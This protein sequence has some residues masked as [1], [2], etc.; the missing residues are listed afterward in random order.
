[1][2]ED[3]PDIS[4]IK[5]ALKSAL[6]GDVAVKPF[7]DC[8]PPICDEISNSKQPRAELQVTRAL[9]N[10]VMYID[11]VL[12]DEECKA[13]CSSVDNSS[14]LSFWSEAG[15]SNEKA[16]SFRDA[17]TIEV[18]SQEIADRIWDRIKHIIDIPENIIHIGED[19]NDINNPKWERELPG[20]W[21]PFTTNNDLLFAK[22]PS[23][24][25]FAPHTDGRATHDF[26]N[27][28]FYSIIIL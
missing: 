21:K 24:G 16:R 2:E 17:D 27:R 14:S 18:K 1:M 8:I 5:P 12:S 23:G 13:L 3:K 10:K 22:Y 25:S 26:N 11:N 9:D 20:D 4:Y 6:T 7:L 28:S 19:E 15:R